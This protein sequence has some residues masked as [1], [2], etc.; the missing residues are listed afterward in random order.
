MALTNLEIVLTLGSALLY[1]LGT[2]QGGVIAEEVDKYVKATHGDEYEIDSTYRF[3]LI[4][5]W[6]VATIKVLLQKNE[7]TE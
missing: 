5:L 7:E 2:H 3:L 1:A 4:W 6:P